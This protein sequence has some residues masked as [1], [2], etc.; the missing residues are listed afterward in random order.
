M[1]K[2]RPELCAS[3]HD[4]SSCLECHAGNVRPMRIHAGD[5]LSTH[6][7]EARGSNNDCQACHRLQSDCIACHDRLGLSATSGA[8]FQGEGGFAFH[9]PGFRDGVGGEGHAFAAQRN[10]GACASC[11]DEDT[12]LACHA[13]TNVARPGLGVSPHGPGFADSMRCERLAEANRRVCLRCH[14]PG[15]PALSCVP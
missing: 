11:H 6:G 9:P 3:C 7:L 10:L 8:G 12:C 14:A 4:D 2:A 5:F 13:T 1:A 15:E